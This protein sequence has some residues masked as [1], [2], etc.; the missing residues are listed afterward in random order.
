MFE[1]ERNKREINRLLERIEQNTVRQ[2]GNVAV[3]FND[4]VKLNFL[5]FYYFVDFFDADDW[6][7][8]ILRKIR[9]ANVS[10]VDKVIFAA[11]FL[12]GFVN[13]WWENFDVMRSVES[14]V[15]G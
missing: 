2:F 4:F 3:F 10:E 7:C 15:Y 13:L 14:V 9:S 12:E 1:A 11:Y 5:K 6:L 8:S